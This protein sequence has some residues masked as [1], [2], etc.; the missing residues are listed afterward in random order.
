MIKANKQLN[1]FIT[2]S[3][4]TFW[5]QHLLSDVLLM[6]VNVPKT[7]Y[8]R[9]DIM[10]FIRHHH[11]PSK[12]LKTTH[13]NKLQNLLFSFFLSKLYNFFSFRYE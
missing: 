9:R 10:V 12:L 7:M 2:H 3:C 11:V 13:W 8:Y 1:I 6:F 5:F 4:F